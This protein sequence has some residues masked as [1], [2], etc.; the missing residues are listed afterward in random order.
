MNGKCSTCRTLVFYSQFHRDAGGFWSV[1]HSMVDEY[2]VMAR[3]V[4]HVERGV[5]RD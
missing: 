1:D 4:L 2:L 3:T 5:M